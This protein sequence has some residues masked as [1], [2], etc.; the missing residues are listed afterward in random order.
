MDVHSQQHRRLTTDPNVHGAVEIDGATVW[1]GQGGIEY[2]GQTIDVSGY[3]GNHLI[4]LFYS[5]DLKTQ[6]LRSITFDNIG[7]G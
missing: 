7:C 1:T 4:T 2:R 3:T 6:H 5:L